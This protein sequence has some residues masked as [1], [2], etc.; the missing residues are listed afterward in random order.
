MLSPDRTRAVVSDEYS[1]RGILIRMVS[2][3]SVVARLGGGDPM[4]GLRSMTCYGFLSADIV[5][6]DGSEVNSLELISV[7][8][9][10]V[11]DTILD[12]EYE[13]CLS[14][15]TLLFKRRS[16]DTNDYYA[17]DTQRKREEHLFSSPRT[18]RLFTNQMSPFIV[19]WLPDSKPAIHRKSDGVVVGTVDCSL[20]AHY[21]NPVSFSSSGLSVYALHDQRNI[22]RYDLPEGSAKEFFPVSIGDG[23]EVATYASIGAASIACLVYG[24]SGESEG[25]ILRSSGGEIQRLAQRYGD[26]YESFTWLSESIFSLLTTRI[27]ASYE[28]G[29][30]NYRRILAVRR[31]DPIAYPLCDA[32]KCLID[33]DADNPILLDADLSLETYITRPP[34]YERLPLVVLGVLRGSDSV[35]VGGIGPFQMVDFCVDPFS[36]SSLPDTVDPMNVCLSNDGSWLVGLTKDGRHLYIEDVF[37]TPRFVP[38]DPGLGDVRVVEIAG[39]AKSVVVVGAGGVAHIEIVS[40][41]QTFNASIETTGYDRWKIYQRT[42]HSGQSYLRMVDPRTIR[43]YRRYPL[44]SVDYHLSSGSDGNEILYASMDSSGKVIYVADERGMFRMIAASDLTVVDSLRIE[45]FTATRGV[46]VRTSFSYDPRTRIATTINVF[47]E[48]VVQRW[49]IRTTSV[50]NPSPGDDEPQVTWTMTQSEVVLTLLGDE[51]VESFTMYSLIGET[52]WKEEY[53]NCPATISVPKSVQPGFIAI[54][55]TTNERKFVKALV[56]N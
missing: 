16:G 3:W 34:P 35:L 33:S 31:F 20:N 21:S 8:Q 6:V 1:Q 18:T 41:E 25:V 45:G 40:M 47:G 48:L 12:A 24:Q 49:P 55:V 38:L 32:A 17:Y 44:D 13:A 5:I 46:P 52:L 37:H 43:L 22:A 4:V 14:E 39:D 54:V 42:D 56:I 53:R 7:S 27:I 28:L 30:E 36:E 29:V 9:D 2:D 10:A 19:S 26:T 51:C 23:D 50:R 15:S 11:I